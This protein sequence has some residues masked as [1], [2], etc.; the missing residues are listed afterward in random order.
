MARKAE[1]RSKADQE[2]IKS[3]IQELMLRNDLK[4]RDL[5]WFGHMVDYDQNH[6]QRHQRKPW[7]ESK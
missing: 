2:R 4:K 7:E 6:A 1:R 5:F 3:E